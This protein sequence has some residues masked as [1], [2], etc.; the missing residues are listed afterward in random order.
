MIQGLGAALAAPAGLSLL[1]T[2]FTGQ[3][4]RRKAFAVYAAVSGAG[5][6][7]GVL[8]GG[9]FTQY[10]SWRGVLLVNV[11]VGGALALSSYCYLHQ[12]QRL[13]GR[14]D[15]AGALLSVIG[16]V[17]LVYGL[18]RAADT[19]WTNATTIGALCLAV[20]SLAVFA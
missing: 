15:V 18:I 2:T 1:S 9:V 8:L 14:V 5:A 16:M 6:A 3:A 11:P 17:A 19:S 20:A 13:R 10:L 12:S 4:E 7:A